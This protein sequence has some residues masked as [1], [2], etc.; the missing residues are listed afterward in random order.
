MEKAIQ[1]H[2]F[3]RQGYSDGYIEGLNK[4]LEYYKG[5]IINKPTE[6]IISKEALT[7]II[8]KGKCYLYNTKYCKPDDLALY[9]ATTCKSFHTEESFKAMNKLL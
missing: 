5:Q 8:C 7:D 9:D 3:Y 6:I 1:H 4:A 2:E